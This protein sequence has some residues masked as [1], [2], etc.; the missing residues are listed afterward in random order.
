MADLL[1]KELSYKIVG[2]LFKVHGKLGGGYQE[3]YYQKAIAF[4]LKNSSINFQEQV[5]VPLKY[6]DSAI[7]RYFM[8]FVIEDKI[9]LEIKTLPRFYSRDIKQVLSY[10]KVSNL[11]LGILASFSRNEVTFKRILKGIKISEN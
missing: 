9:V 6:Q 7:G 5:L 2:I 10:L 3:K 11:S 4:E 1:H 8:D